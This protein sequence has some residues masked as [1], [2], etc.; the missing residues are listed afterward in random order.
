MKP[1][2]YYKEFEQEALLWENKLNQI[3]DVLDVWIDV[4]PRWI[5]LDG[6]FGGSADRKH[7]LQNEM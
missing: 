4:Q 7:L 6:I 2:P 1:S 3:K 5:F